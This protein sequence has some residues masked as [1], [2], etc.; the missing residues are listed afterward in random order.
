M[1]QSVPGS[2]EWVQ[3]NWALCLGSH[4]AE[5]KLLTGA[6]TLIWGSKCSDWLTACWKK[7]F[8][9]D[10]MTEVPFPW[11]LFPGTPL[12]SQRSST[13]PGHVA[14]IDNSSSQHGHWFTSS[15]PAGVWLLLLPFS[16]RASLIRLKPPKMISLLLHSKVS[17]TYNPV[18]GA[19][20]LIFHIW[21][22]SP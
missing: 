13:V 8:P 21:S 12:S 10:C 15:R 3:L 14:T 1:S 11:Y 7:S 9:C 5:M 20:L 2:W 17:W 19:Y 4:Q 22:S 18:M 6:S 16:V